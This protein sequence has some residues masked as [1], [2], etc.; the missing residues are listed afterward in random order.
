MDGR[1]VRCRLRAVRPRR[2]D[3]VTPGPRASRGTCVSAGPGSLRRASRV[4]GSATGKSGCYSGR[5]SGWAPAQRPVTIL[6]SCDRKAPCCWGGDPWV[7]GGAPWKSM[8]R[9]WCHG[10]LFG[11]IFSQS[12]VPG[13]GGI[14]I[15]ICVASAGKPHVFLVVTVVLPPTP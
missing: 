9:P 5:P 2:G 3:Q 1:R 4:P 13:P 11:Q 14:I 8:S 7:P 10:G 15:I 6:V 12:G